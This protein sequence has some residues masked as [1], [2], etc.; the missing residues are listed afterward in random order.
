MIRKSI[1]NSNVIINCLGPKQSYKSYEDFYRIN[2]SIPKKIAK[3]ARKQNIKKFIH[4]SNLAVDPH[5]SSFDLKSKY[6]GEKE[7]LDEFPD[8]T[9]LR[10][11]TVIGENDYF[12]KIF[13]RQ[14]RLFINFIPVYSDLGSLRQPIIDHDIGLSVLNAIKSDDSRGKIYEVYGPHQYTLK[15]LYDIMT[16]I[17]SIN[18]TFLKFNYDAAYF[19]SKYISNQYLSLDSLQKLKIDIIPK[20]E[21]N[22]YSL[23]DLGVEPASIIPQM[24]EILSRYTEIHGYKKDDSNL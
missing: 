19:L 3:E 14:S 18:I 2:V 10:L 4:F 6:I 22:L 17:L 9:I 1:E 16:N 15:E 24:N 11:G 13:R 8:A 5:S 21:T 20:K 7:V 23:E 12:Q